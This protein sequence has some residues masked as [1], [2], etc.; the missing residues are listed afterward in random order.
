MALGIGTTKSPDGGG[1]HVVKKQET[2]EHKIVTVPYFGNDDYC[3][4]KLEGDPHGTYVK[5]LNWRRYCENKLS[6]ENPTWDGFIS[7]I[8]NLS[9]SDLLNFKVFLT[10]AEI[11]LP[12]QTDS[13]VVEVQIIWDLASGLILPNQ[14]VKSDLKVT[15]RNSEGRIINVTTVS[16]EQFRKLYDIEFIYFEQLADAIYDSSAHEGVNWV[17]SERLRSL[18]LGNSES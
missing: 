13:G 14:G 10:C 18:L 12:I 7:F 17:R 1:L 11:S 2:A 9:G 16:M 3:L 5:G 15:V 8:E 4:L 6:M